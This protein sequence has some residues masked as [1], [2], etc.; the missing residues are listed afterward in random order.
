[1]QWSNTEIATLSKYYG[2]LTTSEIINKYM[3]QRNRNTL[4]WKAR[5]L[6]LS[7]DRLSMTSRAK[8]EYYANSQ[9]FQGDDLE[10][11]YWAGFLAAD[12]C[13]NGKRLQLSV[14]I[15]DID[16]LRRFKSALSY[17]GQI[18]MSHEDT[19]CTLRISDN[20]LIRDLEERFNIIQRKSLVLQPPSCFKW[21]AEQ[22]A[23][24]AGYI[25][26]DGCIHKNKHG[27]FELSCLGT[28]SMMRFIRNVFFPQLDT[29]ISKRN[30]IYCFKVTG[31]YADD[32]I[33]IVRKMNLPILQRKWH[34]A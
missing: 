15:K 8:R 29:N 23:F 24:A 7:A 14:G 18:T 13:I 9:Y 30:K 34:K 10:V 28:L 20:Q 26:G 1:M 32:I 31:Q 27:R 11:F 12:G 22:I 33:D 19:Y 4:K 3:P 6:G 25:D 2:V 16:H 5:Q 17:D 21:H